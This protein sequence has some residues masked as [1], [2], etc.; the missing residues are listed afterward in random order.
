M[1][2]RP[3]ID[4]RSAVAISLQTVRYVTY[5]GGVFQQ[6][7]RPTQLGW[8]ELYV[9]PSDVWE[10]NE[11]GDGRGGS[12]VSRGGGKGGGGGGEEGIGRLVHSPSNT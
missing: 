11:I 2:L 9:S 7:F 1:F 4:A 5:A 12:D 10:A 8:S 6:V 3:V